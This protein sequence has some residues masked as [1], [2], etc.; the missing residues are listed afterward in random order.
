MEV[1]A[2]TVFCDQIR[3]ENTGKFLIIGAYTAEI[4]SVSRPSSMYLSTFTQIYGLPNGV[5]TVEAIVSYTD[6]TGQRELA[7]IET[8][9]E[10]TRPDLPAAIYPQGLYIEVDK[11]GLIKIDLVIDKD[12]KVAAGCVGLNFRTA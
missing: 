12:K 4:S 1:T 10:I 7:S 2:G 8:N 9:V 6:E 11:P 3:V 5:H